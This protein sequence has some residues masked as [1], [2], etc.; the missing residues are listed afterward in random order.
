MRYRGYKIENDQKPI[1]DRRFDY[2]FQHDNYYGPGD[3][4]AGV[5]PTVEAACAEIDE[6]E[7][8]LSDCP[9]VLHPYM[10]LGDIPLDWKFGLDGDE[11]DG[12]A[13][14]R[15]TF[16]LLLILEG[17]AYC[18]VSRSYDGTQGDRVE[19]PAD[20]LVRP[21]HNGGSDDCYATCRI[22]TVEENAEADLDAVKYHRLCDEIE[23]E[24][25]Q[26]IKEA[27]QESRVIY[28]AYPLSE[29]RFPVNNLNEVAIHGECVLVMPADFC[30]GGEE[31]KDYRS[32][33]VKDPTWKDLA[34]LVNEAIGIVGDG[35]HC[36]FEGVG[37]VKGRTHGDVPV[38]EFYMGS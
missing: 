11:G 29:D 4:R 7:H 33:V 1:P 14:V 13:G 5:A 30:F 10:R 21:H 22:K 12:G 26:A 3:R 35:H 27:G 37:E 25:E 31:S 2:S 32:D 9:V 19:F 38:Y 6:I 17:V 34:I 16:R 24:V 20:K 8:D 15:K 18:K 28:S 23:A 36:F